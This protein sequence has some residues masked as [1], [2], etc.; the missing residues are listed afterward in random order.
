MFGHQHRV[1]VFD[2]IL[3]RCRVLDWPLFNVRDSM[4][5]FSLIVFP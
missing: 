5:Y 3:M 1:F 4:N 2:D